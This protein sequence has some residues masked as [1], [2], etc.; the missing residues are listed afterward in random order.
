M[1]EDMKGNIRQLTH[2]TPEYSLR[3]DDYREELEDYDDLRCLR[4]AKEKE[5]NSPVISLDD[6]K[7]KMVD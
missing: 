5:K 7:K 2:F 4:E 1:R 3:V 6:L